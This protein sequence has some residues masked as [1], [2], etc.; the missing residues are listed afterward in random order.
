MNAFFIVV[1][2][3]VSLPLFY[4]CLLALAA[5]RTRSTRSGEGL[6]HRF[7]I[8][9]PAH[10]EETVIGQTVATLHNLNYPADLYDVF[11]VA[12]HCIDHTAEIA[13]AHGAIC[14]ERTDGVRGGKGA[15]LNWLLTHK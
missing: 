14:L 7:A 10:N 12:D 11:V 2:L 6:R 15:A 13:R 8:A 3:A 5:I 9:I 4:L 1:L